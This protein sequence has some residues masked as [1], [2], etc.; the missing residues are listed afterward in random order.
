MWMKMCRTEDE[1]KISSLLNLIDLQ[2]RFM[3]MVLDTG[4]QN[5]KVTGDVA[6]GYKMVR[7]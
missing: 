6:T 1:E 4:I 7:A 5:F 2:C 3:E